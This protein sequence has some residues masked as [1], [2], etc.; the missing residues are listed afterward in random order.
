[1]VYNMCIAYIRV[2]NFRFIYNIYIELST[3]L[4]IHIFVHH[5]CRRVVIYMQY[6][7][8]MYTQL[9][10]RFYVTENE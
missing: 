5:P 6:A 1:M 2:L 10:K 7:C 3:D 4:R 9:Y 8:I